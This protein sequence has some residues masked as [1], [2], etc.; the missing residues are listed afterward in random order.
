VRG[1]RD[2]HKWTH[3]VQ[4][5]VGSTLMPGAAELVLRGALAGGASMIRLVSRG[6]VAASVELPPEVVHASEHSVDA[7][8]RCVVAGPGLGVGAPAWLR[9][10]LKDVPC[11]VVLDADGLDRAL[12]EERSII[13]DAWVLTP[14]DGEFTRLSGH[15]P[16]PNRFEEVRTLAKDTNSVVLLKGPVTIIAKPTGELR[17]VNSGTPTLATAGT[18]DVLAGLI[19]ATIARGRG[20]FEA[21]ALAAHLHGR[22]GSF[23]EP[24]AHATD[25]ASMIATIVEA[26]GRG[27]EVPRRASPRRRLH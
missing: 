21:A 24:Y 17:V 1:E 3:A 19:A 10:V 2:D 8:S 15:A 16:G 12:I 18:G 27:G 7:R 23:L 4:A 25:V 22:A 26:L 9:E 14:H 11:P 5:F 6:D 13:D 20:P